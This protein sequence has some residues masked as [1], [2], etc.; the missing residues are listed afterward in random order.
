MQCRS[1]LVLNY[2]SNSVIWFMSKNYTWLVGMH[3]LGQQPSNNCFDDSVTGNLVA[4]NSYLLAPGMP[5]QAG[6]NG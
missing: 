1:I 6:T 3:N 4:L 5:I 2:V